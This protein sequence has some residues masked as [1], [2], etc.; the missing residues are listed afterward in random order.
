MGPKLWLLFRLDMVVRVVTGNHEV[1]HKGEEGRDP[2][3]LGP[4]ELCYVVG[5]RDS[6]GE[7]EAET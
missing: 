1:G 4:W 3:L 5:P 6:G 2:Q 7:I